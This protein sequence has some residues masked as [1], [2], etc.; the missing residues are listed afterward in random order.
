MRLVVTGAGGMLG[1]DV[2]R[3]A[4]AAGH[5]AIA[6]T[7]ADLDVTDSEAVAERLRAEAPDWVV[8]CAAYTNVDG[9]EDDPQAATAGNADAAGHVAAGAAEAGAG[10]TYPSTDYV[11]DGLK[12]GAY[13]ESDPT[14]PLS[15]YG[16]TKLAGER[17]TAAANSR[18]QIVRTSWL[19]GTGG[20]NFVE[21]MLRLAG[22]HD[23]VRVVHDQRGCPTYTPHLAVALVELA[24]SDAV[25]VR[26]VSGG[27]QATWFEFAE[28]IFR[29][30]GSD[31]PPEPTTTAEFPRPAPRPANS[32]LATEVADCPRLPQWR[33]GLDAYLGE[34]A[35]APA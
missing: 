29:R 16:Q 18:H 20:R 21:T 3:A 19:F 33:E 32:V 5:E 4:A 26:H 17:T 28:D 9:A 35:E 23:Q 11:F 12:E 24:E 15:V 22:E 1:R 31:G 6:L 8:N 13:L 2:V 14:G 30:A 27:G 34:R 10:I 7:R 25:G